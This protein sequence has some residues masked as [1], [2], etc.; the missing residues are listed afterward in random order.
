M[1]T[2]WLFLYDSL[3]N[4]GL[5]KIRLSNTHHTLVAAFKD[6]SLLRQA[7]QYDSIDGQIYDMHRSS[8][9]LLSWPERLSLYAY[10]IALFFMM[11]CISLVSLMLY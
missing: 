9:L 10:I 6:L 11:I 5:A 3:C 7:F 4:F 2:S 1:L 8:G